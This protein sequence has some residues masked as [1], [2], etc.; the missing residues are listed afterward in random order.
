MKISYFYKN[1]KIDMFKYVYFYNICINKKIYEQFKA[2][3]CRKNCRAV[4][5]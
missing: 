3:S 2:Y 1:A 4:T 5:V